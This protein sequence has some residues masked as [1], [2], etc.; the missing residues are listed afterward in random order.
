MCQPYDL[1][2]GAEFNV[3][4]KSSKVASF[5]RTK[6]EAEGVLEEINAEIDRRYD[7]FFENDVSNIKEYNKNHKKN[8]LNYEV[9]IID[10]FADLQDEKG[11][12]GIIET[13]AAK[14]R[15][16]GIHLVISTQRP[17][18]KILNGRIKANVSS[19]LGLKTINDIN[20]RII[21]DHNG[22]EHLRGKGHG[23]FKRSGEIEIQCPNLS[24]EDCRD[25][26]K[27]TYIDKT[28]HRIGGSDASN[29]E[30]QTISLDEL[31]DLLGGLVND[32]K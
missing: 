1:K 20:S 4:A 11:S 17:D 32:K 24:V 29:K 7:L 23:L 28:S 6:A 13:V 10:E 9:V 3:F 21:I 31:G 22:L 26:I 8:K 30:K 19:I 5:S 25:L 27:H 18:A 14:A 2:R 12:I 15:A 16:C